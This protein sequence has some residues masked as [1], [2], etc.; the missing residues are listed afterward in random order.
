MTPVKLARKR[1]ACPVA[2]FQGARGATMPARTGKPVKWDVLVLVYGCHFLL[3]HIHHAETPFAQ[4]FQQ[5]VFV[6][7]GVS[8]LAI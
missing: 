6:D 5:L 7:H 2:R 4:L 8:T 3:G 1:H